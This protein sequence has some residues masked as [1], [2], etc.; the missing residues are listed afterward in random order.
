MLYSS[1][2]ILAQILYAV[3]HRLQPGLTCIRGGGVCA[4]TVE[5]TDQGHRTAS[6]PRVCAASQKLISQIRAE[7]SFQNVCTV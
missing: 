3:L 6:K 7:R 2:Y 1:E 4:R 5:R